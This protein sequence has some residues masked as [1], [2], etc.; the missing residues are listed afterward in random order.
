MTAAPNEQAMRAP[1]ST[2]IVDA[3]NQAERSWYAYRARHALPND[4]PRDMELEFKETFCAG[5]GT[6]ARWSMAAS[7]KLSGA[8]ATLSDFLDW[9]RHTDD[10]PT[11][12]LEEVRTA[13]RRIKD[14]E[15]D[16]IVAFD[17]LLGLHDGSS[18]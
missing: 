13:W 17:E 3:G 15:C 12:D 7:S 5:F 1:Q 8:L 14:G 4:F 11:L 9:L 10:A 6:G 16:A 18:T 2:W